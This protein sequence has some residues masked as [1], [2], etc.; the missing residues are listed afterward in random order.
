MSLAW[1]AV[2]CFFMVTGSLMHDAKSFSIKKHLKKIL[3]TYGILCVWK[4]IY[5]V[6]YY[7]AIDIHFSKV[8]LVNYLFLFGSISGIDTGHLWFMYAYLL[9]LIF[10]PISYF[11]ISVNNRMLEIYF[12]ILLFIAGIGIHTIQ[13]LT[14]LLVEFFGF[15]S[16]NINALYQIIPFGSYRNMLFY[17]VLGAILF[18]KK[19]YIIDFLNKKSISKYLIITGIM[20]GILGN[21]LIKFAFTNSFRWQGIYLA[22]GYNQLFT[23]VMSVG[24]YLFFLILPKSKFLEN[25]ADSIGKNTMGIYFLHMP[26]LHMFSI[27]LYSYFVPYY[28]FGLNI[29]KTIFVAIFCLIITK[30]IKKIPYVRILVK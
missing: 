16:I 7:I 30:L 5:F 11:I 25:F 14:T 23:M 15:Q 17:F 2:P 6:L 26:V 1:S 27:I 20:V 19:Q 13:F 24:I 18:K 29:L 10:Y 4:V 3:I 8:E 12:V 21:M 28:S 9:V 22:D